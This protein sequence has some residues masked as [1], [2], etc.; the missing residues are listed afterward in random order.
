[1]SIDDFPR[2]EGVPDC[3]K[4]TIMVVPGSLH[5][6][7]DG[8]AVTATVLVT[9]SYSWIDVTFVVEPKGKDE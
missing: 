4:E 6:E 5:V 9:K 8:D 1:M 2:P 3:A 7:K